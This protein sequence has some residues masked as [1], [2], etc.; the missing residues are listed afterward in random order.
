MTK[1]SPIVSHHGRGVQ[2]PRRSGASEPPRRAL[3]R[4]RADVE[5]ARGAPPDD[6]VRRHEAPQA[7]RGGGPGRHQA[8]RAREAP[9]PESGPHP[10]RPRPL[11]EQVRRA[12]G[13]R[14]QR[15][16]EPTGGTHGEGFRDLHQDDPGAPLGG[17]HRRRPE[18]QVLLRRPG[19]LRLDDRL[20]LRVVPSLRRRDRRGREPRGRPPAPAGP[21]LQRPV[22]RRRQERGD[23]EGHV[24][25]R[26][27]RGLLPPDRDPR[28]ASRGRERRALRR[29]A[30]DP[31]RPEDLARDGHAADPAGSA[32]L[33]RRA[34]RPTDTAANRRPPA[35]GPAGFVAGLLSEARSRPAPGGPWRP[36]CLPPSRS[37]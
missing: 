30:D 20:A 1:L 24:G 15:A 8:A 34:G 10:A 37:R 35:T 23:L 7:A 4:G 19:R 2:S 21:E 33:R 3:P 16:Q 27:G 5:R 12:L 18:E 31:L 22:E 25:D 13:R 14:A 17:D 32:A 29:L 26:A 28:P 36:A 9:L 11:G 6:A